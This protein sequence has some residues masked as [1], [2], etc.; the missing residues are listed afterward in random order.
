M[1]KYKIQGQGAEH[2]LA[3]RV[4]F[5]DDG[6][7]ETN[8]GVRC[9]VLE[10][11]ESSG[12]VKEYTLDERSLRREEELP[13]IADEAGLIINNEETSESKNKLNRFGAAAM[14]QIKGDK[15]NYYAYTAA[16][17]EDTGQ[18]SLDLND[19]AAAAL[20]TAVTGV[21]R[22]MSRATQTI[23]I[24]LQVMTTKTETSRKVIPAA[25]APR[26]KLTQTWRHDRA[27]TSARARMSRVIGNAGEGNL[28][29]SDGSESEEEKYSSSVYHVV[30][31]M[32]TR[33]CDKGNE[34]YSDRKIKKMAR[35]AARNKSRVNTH[36]SGNKGNQN[37][38]VKSGKPNLETPNDN[39]DYQKLV[40][41]IEKMDHNMKVTN[42]GKGTKY[43][44]SYACF[45]CGEQG[46]FARNCALRIKKT[47]V[48]THVPE[49]K[50]ETSEYPQRP[51]GG[52][53]NQNIH[54]LK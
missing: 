48:L 30:N 53:I 2:P 15:S 3:D 19:C 46:Q 28:S 11:S 25:M 41:K 36:S 49:T 23:E 43:E 14:L 40:E 35:R 13:A 39:K 32:Q 29:S 20:N 45:T 26:D 7:L 54:T 12:T 34:L 27:S 6:M 10:L 37:K 51:S 17:D 33:K 50:T 31:F 24:L 47:R 38:K 16:I 52:A 42:Q 18:Y 21:M 1:G 44:L 5:Q 8:T 22:E 9:P 4:Q